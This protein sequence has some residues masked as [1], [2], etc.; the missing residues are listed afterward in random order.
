MVCGQGLLGKNGPHCRRIKIFR[1]AKSSKLLANCMNK[2][3]I[4]RA[5]PAKGLRGHI[6]FDPQGGGSARESRESPRMGRTSNTGR[7]PFCSEPAFPPSSSYSRL[8]AS[9]AGKLRLILHAFFT[10]GAPSQRS[11]CHT[12]LRLTPD[13]GSVAS[14]AESE[15]TCRCAEHEHHGR[16]LR[17]DVEQIEVVPV[18]LDGEIAADVERV[19]KA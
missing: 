11:L 15:Q 6:G 16:R 17:N 13:L 1:F 9:F 5:K 7:R 2:E 8:L 14:S 12:S 18:L 19:L 10:L 3:G 4:S